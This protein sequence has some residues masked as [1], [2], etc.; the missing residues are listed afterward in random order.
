MTRL[1]RN[2]NIIIFQQQ[3]STATNLLNFVE[4]INRVFDNGNQLDVV[5]TDFRKA[6]DL[7]SFDIILKKIYLFGLSPPLVLFFKSYLYNRT[8]YVRYNS[9]KSEP[10]IVNSSVP[11]GSNLGPLLFLLL[12][13]DLPTKIENSIPFLFAD[14]LKLAKEIKCLNDCLIFQK[15]LAAIEEW[16]Q[17]NKLEFNSSKCFVVSFSLK[18]ELILHSYTL[19][20]NTL[21]RQREVKDLGVWFDSKLSFEKHILTKV[22]E[23]FRLFGYI[24]RSSQN[25]VLP[26]TVI[27]LFNTFIRSK[28][29]YC[30]LVW[31]PYHQNRINQIE[32]VQ[33]KFLKYLGRRYRQ[34]DLRLVA[35]ES[36]LKLFNV[37]SLQ[38]R[39]RIANLLYL[40]KLLNNLEN[41]PLL[42]SKISFNVG[43]VN[44]RSQNLFYKPHCRTD[45]SKN[46]PVN[47]MCALMDANPQ[48]DLFCKSLAGFRK[49]CLKTVR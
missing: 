43:R 6:F 17:L 19:N 29:E 22:N 3:R 30:S 35:Y 38:T 33:K 39:R 46:A 1:Q 9:F 26:N 10:Y 48:L 41:N 13:N 12:I 47:R 42:L 20:N 37:S 4:E 21:T 14:D 23:S 45:L 24:K 5:Y 27:K 11:Q 25:F 34:L 44:K 36:V 18:R 40:F 31:N 16:S 32:K 49:K 8:Q 2:N 15:D 7:V 28:L